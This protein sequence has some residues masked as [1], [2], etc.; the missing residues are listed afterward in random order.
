M[1]RIFYTFLYT[2]SFCNLTETHDLD[3]D[4]RAGW[5]CELTHAF[6]YEN[7]K[8]SLAKSIINDGVHR[9]ILKYKNKMIISFVENG[10]NSMETI[11]AFPR[12]PAPNKIL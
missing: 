4:Y 11:K 10:T 3:D 5:V 1:N 8:L 2:Y 9:D 7:K 6:F 12:P